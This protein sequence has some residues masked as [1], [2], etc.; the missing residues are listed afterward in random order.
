MSLYIMDHGL[1]AEMGCSQV[2]HP[3]DLLEAYRVLL[4]GGQLLELPGNRYLEHLEASQ[5]EQLEN[6]NLDLASRPEQPEDRYLEWQS[7]C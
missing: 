4:P 2:F 6:R 1:A 3:P 7:I 5:P